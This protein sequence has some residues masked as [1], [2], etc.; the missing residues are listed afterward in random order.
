MTKP[1]ASNLTKPTSIGRVMLSSFLGNTLE[2]YD[3]V[4]Y[5]TAA[6]L[7]FGPL[8][9]RDLDPATAL[10]ASF[11][12]LAAGYVARPLGGIV[13]GHFG[14]RVGRKSMLVI[15]MTSMGI[16]STAIGLL[17]TY[18]QIGV[19][20]PILLVFFRIVQ[21]ISTG[22]E[23]G[24][25][26]LMAL[27]HAPKNR[28]GFA[29]GITNVG[30]PAGGALA[31]LTLS[32]A[33]ML[34]EDQFLAWGW[35]LPFIASIVLVGIGLWVRLR[36]SESPLFA[37]EKARAGLLST[38]SERRS[39]PLLQAITRHPMGVVIAT[40]GVFSCFAWHPLLASF[41]VN[42]AVTSVGLDQAAVLWA[43]TISQ[44]IQIFAL[45]FFNWLCDRLG[46]RPIMIVG[47]LAG[48]LLA[49]PIFWLMGSG[50]LALFALA[51]TVALMFVHAPIY[52]PSAAFISE[53][54]STRSR[55]SGASLGYQLAALL[56]GGFAPLIAASLF[57]SFG[58]IA[59]SAFAGGVCLI[60][61]IVLA[62]AKDT[63]DIDLTTME[64][65][66]AP[67][68]V[69]GSAV[70]V[71]AASAATGPAA[72]RL[73][74]VRRGPRDPDGAGCSTDGENLALLRTA[75]PRRRLTCTVADVAMERGTGWP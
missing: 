24:G 50:S 33:A 71:P 70:D 26:A 46:R 48:I 11:G 75:R 25:A 32:L 61:L 14:D 27:E 29:A 41:G 44:T 43:V 9:F 17:P 4:L 53:M 37:A 2:V 66:V 35:R 8:F 73:V 67:G 31:G 15:T 57:Q 60:G 12:T 54:F 51:I 6:A 7:V 36:I 30:S 28:R 23:W 59:V 18:D 34:P 22:G 68:D 72:R 49:F 19:L 13:F 56:G 58:I 47:Q 63:R 20:A 40:L 55:Y 52:G 45:L 3:F 1:S 38:S 62:L 65:E 42:Y 10:L 16:A 64:R 39:I 74:S 5:S 69:P 21:G